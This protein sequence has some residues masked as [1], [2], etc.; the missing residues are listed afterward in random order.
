MQ[1]KTYLFRWSLIYQFFLLWIAF[2][3][4]SLINLC[5]ALDPEESLLMF[6]EGFI[7]L[8]FSPLLGKQSLLTCRPS[9]GLPTQSLGPRTLP[10]QKIRN[11][12]SLCH[13]YCLVWEYVSLFQT[14][15]DSF[16][17]LKCVRHMAPGQ[18]HCYICPLRGHE[19][20]V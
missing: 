5:L 13:S 11:P 9:P 6:R 20:C 15:Y 19:G 7:V 3:V 2:L 16:F 12:H 4:S 18:P 1:S 14:Q 17:L 10:N 8:H